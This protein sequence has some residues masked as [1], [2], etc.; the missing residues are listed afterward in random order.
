M[1]KLRG[2]SRGWSL[3]NPPRTE[4]E[5]QI[6]LANGFVELA[7][8]EW[9]MPEPD[10]SPS[11]QAL[12]KYPYGHSCKACRSGF[13]STTARDPYCPSCHHIIN[14]KLRKLDLILRAALKLP[15]E[16]QR[17]AWE[18]IEKELICP[19]CGWGGNQN[20][21]GPENIQEMLGF[22]PRW[23]ETDH[24]HFMHHVF[25]NRF[26]KSL[27]FAPKA[28]WEERAEEERVSRALIERFGGEPPSLEIVPLGEFEVPPNSAGGATTVEI[29]LLAR[30]QRTEES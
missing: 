25:W 7:S 27:R 11:L 14:D 16:K 3:A 1:K 17:R 13:R 30:E 12:Q 6:A 9:V 5:R 2:K 8:G 23:V 21:Y 10:F 29:N 15:E 28:A 20:R 18:N 26:T 24:S 4:E 19:I 22:L